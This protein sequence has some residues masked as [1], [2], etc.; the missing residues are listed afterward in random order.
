MNGH[1]LDV[2][3]LQDQFGGHRLKSTVTDSD[4]LNST[5]TFHWNVTNVND[6]PVMCNTARTDCV[7]MVYDGGS[8]ETFNIR[9]EQAVDGATG[10]TIPRSLG[11]VYNVSGS[12]ILD[13]ANEN[14]QTDNNLPG[15]SD[16]CLEC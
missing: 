8:A 15:S 5:Q 2:T 12:Y 3:T 13:M 1:S 14:E 6:K 11:S 7:L 10:F 16:I 9:D 4:G